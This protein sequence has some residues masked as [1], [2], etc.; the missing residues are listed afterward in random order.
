MSLSMRHTSPLP[1]CRSLC[2]TFN[3]SPP[4]GPGVQDAARGPSPTADGCSGAATPLGDTQ[5]P[6]A[7]IY[8]QQT[9]C[10]TPGQG[11]KHT[12]IHTRKLKQLKTVTRT[13]N[14]NS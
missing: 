8:P 13:H 12:H 3:L 1:H 2:R 10:P 5:R 9:G 11:G 7:Q 4:S 14:N 6:A